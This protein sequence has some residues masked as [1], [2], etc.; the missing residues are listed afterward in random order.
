MNSPLGSF[1]QYTVGSSPV[2]GDTTEGTEASL[3]CQQKLCWKEY[4]FH[5][6]VNKTNPSSMQEDCWI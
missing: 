3:G 6:Y 5:I 2:Q 4:S 1:V